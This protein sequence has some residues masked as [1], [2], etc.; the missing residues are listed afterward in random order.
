M[1]MI[2]STK[3]MSTSGVMLIVEIISSS[4][5]AAAAMSALLGHSL[6]A[7]GHQKST[8][9]AGAFQGTLDLVL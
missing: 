2:R 4:F 5:C 8:D 7:A 3:K 9:L 1:K 6:E